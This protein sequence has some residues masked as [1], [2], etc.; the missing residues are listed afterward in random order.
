M[1]IDNAGQINLVYNLKISRNLINVILQK[2]VS[3]VFISHTK[4][5]VLIDVLKL[6]PQVI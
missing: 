4:D 2:Y 3:V 1:Y 5:I 6:L